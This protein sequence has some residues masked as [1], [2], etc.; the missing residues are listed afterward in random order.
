L[1]K[2]LQHFVANAEFFVCEGARGNGK[3][4]ERRK[5]HFS[6]RVMRCHNLSLIKEK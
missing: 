6:D 4:A 1:F 3:Q 5:E 2:G